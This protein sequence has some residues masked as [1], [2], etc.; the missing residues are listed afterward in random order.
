[1]ETSGGQGSRSQATTELRFFLC[2]LLCTDHKAYSRQDESRAIV[3]R[4]LH[5]TH[6]SLITES[7]SV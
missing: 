2:V 3:G 1:M 6:V 5:R 7:L 4:P